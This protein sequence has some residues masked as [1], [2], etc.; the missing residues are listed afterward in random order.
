MIIVASCEKKVYGLPDVIF[1]KITVQFF[2]TVLFRQTVGF[3]GASVLF[4]GERAKPVDGLKETRF[5]FCFLSPCGIA[6]RQLSHM[7]AFF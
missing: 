1:L 5:V 6:A 3:L 4:D 7:S 2:L